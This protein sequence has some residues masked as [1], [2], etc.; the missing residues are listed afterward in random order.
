MRAKVTERGILIPKSLLEGVSEVEI[1][2]EQSLIIVKPVTAGDPILD[3]G[4]R[5]IVLDVEDAS[6]N[7]DRYLYGR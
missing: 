4:K 2:K 3:L 7:H 1:S 5:P 6:V